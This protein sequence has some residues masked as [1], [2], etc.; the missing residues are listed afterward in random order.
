MRASRSS[1]RF[2]ASWITLFVVG[3]VIASS[4][5]C[6]SSDDNAAAGGAADAAVDT[7]FDLCS[8]FTHSGDSCAVASNKPCFGC[9]ATGGCYCVQGPDGL[10]WMC[11]TDDACVAGPG[12]LED[13]TLPPPG[14]GSLPPPHDGGAQDTGTPPVDTGLPDTSGTADANDG[15][16]GV[17][18][19][20][21]APE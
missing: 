5:G 8:T 18:A 17:D 2:A 14:D 20:D 16:T 13:A 9:G 21:G 12:P 4:Q 3:T 7:T 1:S 11:V 15:A 10:R 19:N 6:S